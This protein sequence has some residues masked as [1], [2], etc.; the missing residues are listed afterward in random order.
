[1]MELGYTNVKALLGG[2]IA[3]SDAELPYTGN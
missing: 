1:M 2:L 3:W